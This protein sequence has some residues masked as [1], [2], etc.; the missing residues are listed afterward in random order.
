LEH[1]ILTALRILTTAVVV[2]AGVLGAGGHLLPA[3][4]AEHARTGSTVSTVAATS[5]SAAA[6]TGGVISGGHVWRSSKI[7][8]F[9]KNT[10]PANF[11]KNY[12]DLGQIATGKYRND[13]TCTVSGGVLDITDRH[14]GS[15][16]MGAWIALLPH[17]SGASGYA[18]TGNLRYSLRIKSVSNK[19]GYGT[20]ALL[21]VNNNDDWNRD[22]E[23][24]AW[25]GNNGG[26]A[27]LFQH[28]PGNA[29]SA[30]QQSLG[31][32]SSYHTITVEWIGGVSTTYYE[33]GKKVASFGPKQTASASAK[34][35][36]IV[37]TAASDNSNNGAPDDAVSHV[38]ID[39]MAT[40]QLA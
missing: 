15:Y 20:D 40:W 7:E 9:S 10:T 8:T 27:H 23:M 17:G 35:M 34:F 32:T 31:W 33:D 14:S 11:A 22:G 26:I 30:T 2:V 16:D 6:P 38:S 18:Y 1:I 13:L 5:S 24:D 37:Q 39:W 4:R 12:S 19:G 28:Q 25:E 3:T 36:A 21:S 29:P